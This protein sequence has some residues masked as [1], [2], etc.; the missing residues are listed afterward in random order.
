[1]LILWQYT[2]LRLTAFQNFKYVSN[3]LEFNGLFYHIKIKLVLKYRL[4]ANLKEHFNYN[5]KCK[6]L[7][8]MTG[9]DDYTVAHKI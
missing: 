4:Y 9:L 2:A 5:G 8:S 6:H 7:I 3:A 1:M